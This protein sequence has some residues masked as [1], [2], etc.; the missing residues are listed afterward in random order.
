MTSGSERNRL[1]PNSIETGPFARFVSLYNLVRCE[2]GMDSFGQVAFLR[3][4]QVACMFLY[5]RGKL[6]IWAPQ[7]IRYGPPEI[8]GGPETPGCWNNSAS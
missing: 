4:R 1:V 6:S 3:Q 5:R 2:V 8:T 7:G